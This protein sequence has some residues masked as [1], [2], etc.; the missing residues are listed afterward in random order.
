MI[1]ISSSCITNSNILKNVEFLA[2]NKIS[3]IEL[4]GGSDFIPN[5]TSELLNLK[6]RYNLNF[7]VHNYFP[8]PK[9]HFILNLASLDDY[10]WKKTIQFMK[11]ALDT[12]EIL[13]SPVYG[14][15]AGFYVNPNT[16]EIG[17]KFKKHEIFDKKKAIIRFAEGFNILQDYNNNR[18]KL[19]IENNVL[20]LE[21]YNSYNDNPFMLTTYEEF[22][23]LKKIINFSLLFD[24][25]HYKVTAN[26]L[27]KEFYTTTYKWAKE[28]EY[29]HISDN[30]GKKDMNLLPETDSFIYNFLSQTKKTHKYVTLETYSSIETLK[31]FYQEITLCQ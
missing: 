5:C 7:L 10:I 12:A 17:K 20:S 26:S 30:N 3:N 21:N 24:V 19:Y 31:K 25:G 18:L 22:E 28:C 16:D 23:E 13:G 14:I 29:I 2:N 15:H 9:Q 27:Q 8:P 4:S 6:K 11:N 1:Y